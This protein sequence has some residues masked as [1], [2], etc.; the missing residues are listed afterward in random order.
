M[1][2][3]KPMSKARMQL[4]SAVALAIAGVPAQAVAKPSALAAQSP[5]SMRSEAIVGTGTQAI[6]GTGTQAIVGTGTR[7]IVGTGTQAIVGTGT[8]AIVGTGTQAIVGTGTQAIVGTGTQ[9]IVGTGTQAIVG[10]GTQAIVGTG[11]NSFP[12]DAVFGPAISGP[13]EAIDQEGASVTV[14]GIPVRTNSSTRF[15]SAD[16]SSLQLGDWVFVTG[17]SSQDGVHASALHRSSEVFVP[18][19]SEVFVSGPVTEVMDDIGAVKIG[20]ASVDAIGMNLDR[21]QVGDFVEISG[22]QSQP[23]QAITPDVVRFDKD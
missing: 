21:V 6:V 3:W 19:V 2:K 20:G 9:A 22:S 11:G 14:L 5:P 1:K 7:A 15:T 10:T 8:R 23:R 12:K 16:L 17:I 18:G 4:A 13:V